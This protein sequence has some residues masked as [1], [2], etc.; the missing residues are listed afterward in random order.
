MWPLAILPSCRSSTPLT[1]ASSSIDNSEQGEE[2]EDD[3]RD[4]MPDEKQEDE[5][6]GMPDEEQED[7]RDGLME[8]EL[9]VAFDWDL[10]CLFLEQE[11]GV[12]IAKPCLNHWKET[13]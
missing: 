12:T 10:L 3:T 5:R 2:Q 7:E 13:R 6:D 11:G 9:D 8:Q 4:G 1:T